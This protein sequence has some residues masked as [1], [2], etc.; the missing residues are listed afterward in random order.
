[1]YLKR[2][3]L[4]NFRKFRDKDNS[5]SFADPNYQELAENSTESYEVNIGFHH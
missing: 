2:F 3:E 4:F 5:V 1:M